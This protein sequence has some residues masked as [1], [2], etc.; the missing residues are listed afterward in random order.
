MIPF[1]QK[2]EHYTHKRYCNV[3]ADSGYESEENYLYLETHQQPHFFCFGSRIYTVSNEIK[4]KTNINI[5]EQ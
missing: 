4:Y 2:M 5:E 1:L 3:V